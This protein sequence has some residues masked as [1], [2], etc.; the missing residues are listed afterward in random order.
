MNPL[1]IETL[2]K[3]IQ[4]NLDLA[5]QYIPAT[6]LDYHDL[7]QRAFLEELK[8]E[9]AI[10]QKM[11]NQPET[12]KEN[13]EKRCLARDLDTTNNIPFHIL[14]SSITNDLYLEIALCIYEPKRAIDLFPILMPNITSHINV[15]LPVKL[16]RK[17]ELKNQLISKEPTFVVEKH[18]FSLSEIES[19]NALKSIAFC[20]SKTIDLQQIAQFDLIAQHLFW[21]KLKK[22]APE[23]LGPIYSHNTAF[24]NLLEDIILYEQ[25]GQSL[26]QIF[27]ILIRDLKLGGSRYSNKEEAAEIAQ[28]AIARFHEFYHALDNKQKAT[29]RELKSQ[30]NKTLG[31]II[32]KQLMT[33]SC[34]ETLAQDL[35]AVVQNYQHSPFFNEVSLN[36]EQLKALKQKYSKG[37]LDCS[38]QTITYIM[39]PKALLFQVLSDVHNNLTKIENQYADLFFDSPAPFH[40][41]LIE[42]L[43]KEEVMC[44]LLAE[45]D[46]F[47]NEIAQLIKSGVFEV[48]VADKLAAAIR[49]LLQLDEALNFCILTGKVEYGRLLLQ[50]RSSAELLSALQ[51]L[52]YNATL[53]SQNIDWFNAVVDALEPDDLYELLCP[54]FE[55]MNYFFK[56]LDTDSQY[57]FMEYT[58]KDGKSMFTEIPADFIEPFLLIY[59]N[60]Y[61]RLL[62]H[63]KSKDQQGEIFIFKLLKHPD[64]LYRI[65]ICLP[66]N[67]RE[68]LLYIKDKQGKRVIDHAMSLGVYT[69]KKVLSCINYKYHEAI[70]AEK[71]ERGFLV[72]NWLLQKLGEGE[73]KIKSCEVIIKAI[74]RE[75]HQECIFRAL[76]YKN[77][78]GLPPF[79]SYDAYGFSL[80]SPYI[81]S[82]NAKITILKS[83][84]HSGG[85]LLAYLATSLSNSFLTLFLLNLSEKELKQLFTPELSMPL[86]PCLSQEQQKLWLN[87]CDEHKINL[88]DEIL[89]KPTSVGCRCLCALIDHLGEVT[90]FENKKLYNCLIEQKLWEIISEEH[91]DLKDMAHIVYILNQQINHS[92]QKDLFFF[93]DEPQQLLSE[94]RSC[95][96]IHEFKQT[97]MQYIKENPDSYCVSR[98]LE[99]SLGLKNAPE[100]F[101]TLEKRWN[102][103]PQLNR[104]QEFK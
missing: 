104:K 41:L 5:N 56:A 32:D 11:L 13:F 79:Y 95:K 103:E 52:D 40:H 59:K 12:F 86:L 48:D 36:K 89:K 16:T 10:L 37:N 34:V 98:L 82:S 19:F 58:T 6:N 51:A 4:K 66:E 18:L 44:K 93:W 43:L 83:S 21:K 9:T 27:E 3:I 78:E 85:S 77:K 63:L 74:F 45:T 47:S 33:G 69:F 30:S 55:D 17:E 46:A 53:L 50:T 15:S 70:Y 8:R 25:G 81:K 7:C 54:D 88:L 96:T 38:R 64:N 57:A 1:T 61:T 102:I 73:E 84:H 35:D 49:D 94:I 22:E 97:V 68:Q 23:L 65:T 99:D 80:V 14:Q 90:L 62:K 75:Y 39:P 28:A 92:P 60:N 20:S 42:W 2:K 72:L 76:F 29:L 26:K 31:D 101:K 91:Q 24:Q 71:D 67:Q 100:G 87:W